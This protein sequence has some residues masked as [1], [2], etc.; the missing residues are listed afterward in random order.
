MRSVSKSEIKN[1]LEKEGEFVHYDFETRPDVNS[2]DGSKYYTSNCCVLQFAE[3]KPNGKH[4]QITFM[5]EDC[6]EKLMEFLF[7]GKKSLLDEKKNIIDLF[8]TMPEFLMV[9]F[10]YELI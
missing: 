10:C 8:P 1:R 4:Q 2:A 3:P 6:V 9:I 5:G 7:F